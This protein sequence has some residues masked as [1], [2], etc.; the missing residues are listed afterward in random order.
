MEPVEVLNFLGHQTNFKSSCGHETIPSLQK[1]LFSYSDAVWYDF[2][3]L[4][5]SDTYGK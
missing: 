1:W 2:S 4:E 5:N 3:V